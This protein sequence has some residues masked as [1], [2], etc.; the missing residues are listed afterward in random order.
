MKRARK[1]KNRFA[2]LVAVVALLVLSGYL[3]LEYVFIVRNV[4]FYGESDVAQDDLTRLSG[5]EFGVSIWNVDQQ[6]IAQKIESTGTVRVVKV[7]TKLPWTVQVEV[8]LRT[9]DYMTLLG[10]DR[11]FVA[12]RLGY[13]VEEVSAAPQNMIYVSGMNLTYADVGRRLGA[14]EEM[15]AAVGQIIEALE[16]QNGMHLVSEINVSQ[17]R[18]IYML[19]ATGTRVELGDGQNIAAKITW[20]CAA[21]NDLN[22][23]GEY[24]GR[25]DVSSGSRA[26]YMPGN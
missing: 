10:T 26:D 23:R 14:S 2:I 21:L 25:L 9:R 18:S 24:G 16:A 12:D 17:L 3:L 15:L 7:E 4:V 20:A 22:A 8:A 19:S 13:A 5:I 6:R 11:I 1:R